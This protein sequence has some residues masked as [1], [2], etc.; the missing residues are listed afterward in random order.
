MHPELKWF[1]LLLL[2]LWIGWL[3]TGGPTRIQE[4]RTHPFLK[5]PTSGDDTRIYSYQ[6]IKNGL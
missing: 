4:N 1:L 5:Q 3:V 2:G 6:E